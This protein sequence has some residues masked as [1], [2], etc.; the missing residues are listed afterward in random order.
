MPSL[1]KSATLLGLLLVLPA[2]WAPVKPAPPEV[3]V[4]QSELAGKWYEIARLPNFFQGKNTVEAADT[5]YPN[6]DGSIK[7]IYS[8]RE[9]N[10]KA[11]LKTME[12]KMWQS[13]LTRGTGRFKIQFFW[14]FVA[15]Y[16]IIKKEDDYMV[17]GYP[18]KS[19]MW[20]MSR[21]PQMDANTYQKQLL[22][23]QQVGYDITKVIKTPQPTLE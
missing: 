8:Y 14:P 9:N 23:L 6:P 1:V 5:Y 15:D 7:V 12:A 13:D 10:F 4:T 20:I 18:D 3:R 19:M 2:C 21:S 22:F 16:W 11:P 17:I